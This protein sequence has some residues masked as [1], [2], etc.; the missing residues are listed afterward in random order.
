MHLELKEGA[1]DYLYYYI[2]DA[3]WHKKV[4][5]E[6]DMLN[7]WHHVVAVYDASNS[8]LSKLYL[9]GVEKNA[10]SGTNDG[11]T[12]PSSL[13]FSDK[14]TIIGSYEKDDNGFT[15]YMDE[16]AVWNTALTDADVKAIYND[17]TPNNLL[18]SASYGGGSDGAT[19]QSGFLK[20]Y[21]P[22]EDAIGN[23]IA[24]I[25]K[26]WEFY[27][28]YITKALGNTYGDKLEEGLKV[29]FGK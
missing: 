23:T 19:D 4:E 10:G 28:E 6:A 11:G 2:N 5:I 29:I 14:K 9:N 7:V 17:G 8:T 12:F 15:G 13:D 24:N 25:K 21:Y 16:V 20:V 26:D 1:T 3:G 22:M 18:L 27:K